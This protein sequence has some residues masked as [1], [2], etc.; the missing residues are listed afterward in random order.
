[1][2]KNSCPWSRFRLKKR[3][4]RGSVGSN[5]Q[6]QATSVPIIE[7]ALDKWI[8]P[9]LGKFPLGRI[10]NGTVELLVQD[11]QL[12][13]LSSKTQNAYGNIIKQVVVSVLTDS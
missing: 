10:H 3:E 13:K 6:S 9:H 7:S 2:E 4:S 11:M 1:M 12:A 8:N 5:S